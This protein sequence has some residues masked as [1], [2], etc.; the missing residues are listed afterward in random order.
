MGGNIDKGDRLLLEY[1]DLVRYEFVIKKHSVSKTD[2]IQIT[3]N[4]ENWHYYSI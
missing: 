4:T 2:V 3:N 1:T